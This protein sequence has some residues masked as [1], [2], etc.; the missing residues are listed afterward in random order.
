MTEPDPD[1]STAARRAAELA[2]VRVCHHYGARPEF[3]LIGGLAAR[4]ARSME[5]EIRAIGPLSGY[6]D[7][8][9]YSQ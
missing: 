9:R 2:L 4:H 3:V 1:R 8:N 7:Q 5:S 6:P